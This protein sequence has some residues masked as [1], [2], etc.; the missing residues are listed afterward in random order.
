[1][2]EKQEKV[3]ICH[4]ETQKRLKKSKEMFNFVVIYP[5]F[6]NETPKSVLSNVHQ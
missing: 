4:K 3:K 6:Q 5:V 1:M 2:S